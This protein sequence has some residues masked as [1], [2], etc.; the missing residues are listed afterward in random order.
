MVSIVVI[1]AAEGGVRQMDVEDFILEMQKKSKIDDSLT[2]FL[3][4][5][6]QRYV[7][8]NGLQTAVCLGIFRDIGLQ[9]HGMILPPGSEVMEYNGYWGRL[10]RRVDKYAIGGGFSTRQKADAY[11]LLTVPR[12]EY[13]IAGRFLKENGIRRIAGC[14][15]EHNSELNGICY[16][17]WKQ[18]YGR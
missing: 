16:D 7:Y 3:R 6:G 4:T 5:S 13:E 1:L 17:L 15:W 12:E 9:I 10:L 11:V 14:C 18:K 8:G 2:A